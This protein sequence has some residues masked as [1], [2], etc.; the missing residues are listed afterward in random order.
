MAVNENQL[1]IVKKYEFNNILL[2]DIDYKINKS[3]RDCYNNYFQP[4]RNEISYN[5]EFEK[6]LNNEKKLI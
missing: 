2:K 5:I 1:T 4:I 6:I 3:I